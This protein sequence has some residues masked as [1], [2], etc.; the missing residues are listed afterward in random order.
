[1]NRSVMDTLRQVRVTA[2]RLA[3]GARD[4]RTKNLHLRRHRMPGDPS[5]RHHETP[6]EGLLMTRCRGGCCCVAVLFAVQSFAVSDAWAQKVGS[7]ISYQAEAGKRPTTADTSVDGSAAV[8]DSVD[9]ADHHGRSNPRW[10]VH[11]QNTD[12][13]ELAAPFA[14]RYSGTHSLTNQGQVRE[15]TSTDFF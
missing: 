3:A 13:A 8:K 2:L 4:M 9:S 15:T 1:M 11:F 7:A 10:N 6:A 5:Q 12:I 14:A